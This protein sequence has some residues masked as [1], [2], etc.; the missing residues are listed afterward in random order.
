MANIDQYLRRGTERAALRAN[1]QQD[2][3]DPQIDAYENAAWD[4][5]EQHYPALM[6]ASA[7][8]V[9]AG[10]VADV[11]ARAVAQLN[12]AAPKIRQAIVEKLQ[13]RIIGAGAIDPWM[14]DPTVTEI[15][16]SGTRVRILHQ[17]PE[18][19]RWDVVP[20]VLRSPQE[21]SQLADFLCT[22]AGARYQPVRP[23]QTIMW[24]SNGARINVVHES[25]SG[26][27]GPLLTIRKRS[28]GQAM[29]LS[30]LI[31]RGMLNAEMEDFLIQAVRGRANIVIAGATNTGKTTILR[32]VARAAIPPTER[33]VTIEDI[34]EL[35]LVDF[36]PDAVSMIGHEKSDADAADVDVS[37]HALFV[38]ALRM[39]PDRIIVGEIR[40]AETKDVLEAGVTEAGGLLLTVH[41][42]DPS[43]LFG[44][45]YWMLLGAGLE[46]PWD[47]VVQQVKAAFNVIVHITR[48]VNADGELVRRITNI[49]EILE[50]GEIVS[51]WDWDGAD[52]IPVHDP[53]P[54]LMAQIRR[55]AHHGS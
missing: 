2:T 47:T 17:T 29:D 3:R 8:Y 6:S 32:A 15:T 16:V 23:L 34:D 25:I 7:T 27:D 4:W 11:V 36:F 18:G 13:S 28:R 41:L 42:K 12:I 35:Q 26:N 52:W 51:L 37:L 19:P 22:R 20:G 55:Y 43:M 33:I 9:D 10:Q 31:D 48:W 38:N 44:R 54:T 1:L 53:S 30:D 24:P 40:G 49:S 46:M 50:S 39:T 14:N 21:A 45:F 5:I